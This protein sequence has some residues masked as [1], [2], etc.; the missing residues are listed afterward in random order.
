MHFPPACCR[1]L[2]GRLSLAC[3]ACRLGTENG[4]GSDRDK[5]RMM[6]IPLRVAV[7]KNAGTK[8]SAPFVEE[9]KHLIAKWKGQVEMLTSLAETLATKIRELEARMVNFKEE[10]QKMIDVETSNIIAMVMTWFLT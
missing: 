9:V 8:A 4:A 2:L 7:E 1:G 6:N 10:C 5:C 3:L